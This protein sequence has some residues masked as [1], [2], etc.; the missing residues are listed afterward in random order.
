[1]NI[2][3]LYTQYTVLMSEETDALFEAE[4]ALED[5]RELLRQ[6]A[7]QHKLSVGQKKQL[8]DS[9]KKV[10]NALKKLDKLR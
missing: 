2:F 9:L 1:L 6:T 8:D 5:V 10:M 7:P 3:I 4:F